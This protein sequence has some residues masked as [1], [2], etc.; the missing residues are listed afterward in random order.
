MIAKQ[1]YYDT[2]QTTFFAINPDVYS[3]LSRVFDIHVVGSGPIGE[4]TVTVKDAEFSI[5]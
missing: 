4:G 2:R 1:G 5:H 3:C